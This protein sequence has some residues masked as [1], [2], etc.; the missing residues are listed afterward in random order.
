M[1]TIHTALSIGSK[2][3]RDGLDYE[4]INLALEILI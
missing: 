4:Y 3:H 1:K 2:M